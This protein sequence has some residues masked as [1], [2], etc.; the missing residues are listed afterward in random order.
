MDRKVY[1]WLDS[2]GFSDTAIR[3]MVENGSAEDV[4]WSL[5]HAM[6]FGS[7]LDY[8]PM[9]RTLIDEMRNHEQS[10]YKVAEQYCIAVDAEPEYFFTELAG[11]GMYF[12]SYG[13]LAK[14][15]GVID[16]VRRWEIERFVYKRLGLSPTLREK[17]K[18]S[19]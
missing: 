17:G 9:W 6:T 11:Y 14:A 4:A 1:E 8:T 5:R 3:R 7:D 10:I 12:I 13:N 19:R 16:R 18:R 2:E 15:K